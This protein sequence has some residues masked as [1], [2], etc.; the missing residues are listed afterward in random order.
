MNTPSDM[1]SSTPFQV[2][3]WIADPDSGRL[4]REGA[5]VKLEPKVMNVL[6]CLVQHQGRVVSR[7]DLEANVWAGMVVGYDAI[8]GSI[9]KLRKALGDDSHHPQYIETI[10]KRG[11][12]LIAPVTA[13]ASEV[14]ASATFHHESA[15]QPSEK[16]IKQRKLITTGVGLVVAVGVLFFLAIAPDQPNLSTQPPAKS[17][18]IIV[19]PFKNLSDDPGQDYF[20]EGITDDLITDLSRMASVRVIARQSSYY[21]EDNPASLEDI[22]R[23]LDVLYIVEGSV[24][25][26]GKSIRVNVRLTDTA[27]GENIWAKRFDTD[28]NDIFKIQDDITRN[29][30]DAMY[31]TLSGRETGPVKTRGTT[32][33]EA[34]EAF[35]MGQQYI[36]ARSRQGYEQTMNAYQRAIQIDPNYARAYGAM[37]VTITRG[38]RY[39]WSDLSPVEARERALELAN[40]AVALNQTTPEIYWSLGYVHLHRREFDAAE[41]AVKKSVVLSPNYADGYALLANIANWRGKAS[42]AVNYINKATELNPYYTFQYPSTLGLAYYNLGRYGEAITSLREA[43]EHNESALN[44]RLFLAAVYTRLDRMEDAA[45]EIEHVNV[46]RPDVTLSNLDNIL[47]FEHKRLLL[48]LL[49]DLRKAGLPE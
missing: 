11:Y 16:N 14:L 34:Y 39:Q 13:G 35:L 27:K 32:S 37:A 38:Y 42:D 7:E 36:K 25:K 18:S 26:S 20:S 30:M 9:I 5:E 33:F 41:N 45:W 10:S 28:T 22:A 43:L 12:R 29:V 44:P 3:D 2:G 1:G 24:Q 47:P 17:P 23:Q 6:V 40:K 8:S 15:R 31:V 49:E 46:S 21:Y 19:L 4:Y 48:P